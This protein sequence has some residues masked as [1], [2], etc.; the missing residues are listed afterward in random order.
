M[1]E[2]CILGFG[3]TSGP[4]A[5]PVMYNNFKRVVQTDD[6]V[7]I[8][9]EM[10]HDARVIPLKGQ[11]SSAPGW[12]GSSVGRWGRRHSRDRNPEFPCGAGAYHGESGTKGY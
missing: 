10:N 1:A 8:I 12:L 9:N 5:L 2:R 6:H 3:S 7:V 11:A 4:P